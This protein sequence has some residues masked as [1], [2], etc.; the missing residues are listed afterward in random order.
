MASNTTTPPVNAIATNKPTRQFIA[1]FSVL[2][3]RFS[4][5]VM[6]RRGFRFWGRDFVET[7]ALLYQTRAQKLEFLL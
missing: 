3:K 7:R 5:S 1:H 2:F 4:L 6:R